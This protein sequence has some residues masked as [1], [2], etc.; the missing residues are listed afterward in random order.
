VCRE[1]KRVWQERDEIEKAG[2][3]N[4]QEKAGSLVQAAE[5]SGRDGAQGGEVRGFPL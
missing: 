3:F 2:G 4:P 1:E 5:W